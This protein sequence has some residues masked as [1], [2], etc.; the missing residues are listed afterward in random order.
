MEERTK[1]SEDDQILFCKRDKER[2][3]RER[4]N[5][6]DEEI[7]KCLENDKERKWG[8]RNLKP[9]EEIEKDRVHAKERKRIERM[10]KTEEEKEYE[11]ISEKYKK[12]ES[13]KKRTGK[14]HLTQ[15]LNAKKGMRL[16]I[17]EG[18]LRKF[19]GRSSKKSDELQDWEKY[20]Q[21]GSKYS[22][23]LEILNP[24][25]MTR[26]NQKNRDRKE[27]ERKR[28]EKRK[29]GEWDQNGESGEWYWTGEEEPDLDNL[30]QFCFSPPTEEEKIIIKEAEE[31][32]MREYAE[33]MEQE[34]REKRKL[35]EEERKEAMA[36]PIDP[37][38]EQELCAYEQI[39]EDNI[40]ERME[41]MAKCNF[42]DDLNVMK[43]K[44]DFYNKN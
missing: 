5:R 12:R 42:F 4:S 36:R 17:E 31:I 35:K 32:E 10:N 27:E 38:P 37:L 19:K 7:Q 34:K 39:R 33:K 44:M 6:T 25:I 16:L 26:I 40:K 29:Q 24:D 18:R 2:K 15:N 14:E 8:E 3:E 41:A 9:E 1:R 21:K 11:I 43:S 22:Q 13:R 20:I 23:R 30:D 28:R